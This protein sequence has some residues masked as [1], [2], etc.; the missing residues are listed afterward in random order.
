MSYSHG[1]VA[2][3]Q[4]NPSIGQAVGRRLRQ[5]RGELKMTREEAAQAVR[6]WGVPWTVD[7][8]MSFE[9]GRRQ[10][11]SVGELLALCKA[12]NVAAADWL[13]GEDLVWVSDSSAINRAGAIALMTGSGTGEWHTWRS[14]PSRDDEDALAGLVWV[15]DAGETPPT[16]AELHAAGR[17][18]VPTRRVVDSSVKLWGRRLDAER[19]ERLGALPDADANERRARRGRVTRTL[20]EELRREV[21]RR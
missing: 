5:L 13:A 17:L 18:G 21:R 12:F 1:R 10:D 2:R 20:L 16:A 4:A 6:R 3:N 19:D 14:W 9:N 8:V 15:V 11:V 7:V